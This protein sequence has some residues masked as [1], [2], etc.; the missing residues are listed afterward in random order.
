[1][2]MPIR[3]R[4]LREIEHFTH[5]PHVWW[6][7]K[8]VA[9][10]KRYDNKLDSLMKICHIRK[11]SKILEVGCGN[12]EFTQRL[13]RIKTPGTKI[14]AIDVT[15]SLLSLARKTT[16]SPNIVFK[17][18]NLHELSFKANEFDIVCGISILHHVDLTKSLSEIYRVLKPGGEIFFTEPNILNPVIYLGLHVPSLR[19]SMEF[20]Q[21]E[22]AFKRWALHNALIHAG[23]SDVRVRNYDFLYPQTPPSLI[24]FVER[25]GSVI[26]RL[27]LIKEVSGSLLI[28]AK[29]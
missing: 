18:D 26:E 9:G 14:T 17:Q 21:D 8:S 23:F 16:T 1:M 3:D 24:P 29:K 12:G 19:R 25:V 28:Y 10:Q 27:P 4:D 22:T 13:S 11:G 2:Y 6:G 7:L 5:L 20:S 15:P